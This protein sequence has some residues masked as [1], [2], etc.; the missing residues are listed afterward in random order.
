MLKRLAKRMR[1]GVD[2]FLPDAFIFV[3][4]LTLIVLVVGMIVTKTGILDMLMAWY[5]GFSTFLSFSMQMCAIMVLGY[6]MAQS[7]P[8][9]SLLMW[10]T[11]F[12]RT[13]RSALITLMLTVF[14]LSWVNW[15]VGMIAGPILA[16]AFTRK[17]KIDYPILI[18]A[19][20]TAWQG[21]MAGLSAAAALMSATP[22][23]AFE[24]ILGVVPVSETIFSPFWNLVIIGGIA[25]MTFLFVKMMPDET[26]MILYVAP[27]EEEAPVEAEPE[28][29]IA[30][31]LEHSQILKWVFV[32]MMA[33]VVVNFFVKNGFNL[34]TD[35][36]IFIL[37]FAGLLLHKSPIDFVS[38]VY[39]GVKGCAGIILQFPFYG[40]LQGMLVGSG[41]STVIV[42]AIGA[43]STQQTLPLFTYWMAGIVNVFVPS[44]GGQ[45]AVQ[46]G[47]IG[48]SVVNMGLPAAYAINSF[49]FGDISTN[50]IQPFWAL[51]ALSIAGL[52]IKDIWGYCAIA[53]VGWFVWISL[54][55][56]FFIGL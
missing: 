54:C 41:L 49:T 13:P 18:A 14:V 35:I 30:W 43:I 27:Q 20:Y 56:L 5:G 53:F 11:N 1:V 10:V 32:L 28:K 31:R 52:K 44:A 37:I 50:L 46:G 51:P 6:G 19:S 47:I 40:G 42:E 12:G 33:A 45:W 23:H 17:M 48:Q 16:Y 36:I 24:D 15:G 34:T 4:I 39:D 2:R 55:N 38:A 8:V 22:G 25:I 26:D 29:T 21:G 7:K 9:K 3:I